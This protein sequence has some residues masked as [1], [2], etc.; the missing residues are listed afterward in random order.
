MDAN[1]IYIYISIYIFRYLIKSP[2]EPAGTSYMYIP[3][4]G[5]AYVAEFLLIVVI[6]MMMILIMMIRMIMMIIMLNDDLDDK[7]DDDYDAIHKEGTLCLAAKRRSTL[8]PAVAGDLAPPRGLYSWT[9]YPPKS[10]SR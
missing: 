10:S 7:E 8:K 5:L 6:I 1:H 2:Q 9:R 4:D 3:Q